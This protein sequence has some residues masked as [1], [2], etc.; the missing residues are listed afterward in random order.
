[1]KTRYCIISLLLLVVSVWAQEPTQLTNARTDYEK[2]V[3]QATL[4]L[5]KEYVAY[6]DNL[7]KALGTKGD[8][9]GA[10]AVQN[11]IDRVAV[12]LPQKSRQVEKWEGCWEYS[13][14]STVYIR[15]LEK[16][17]L[18]WKVKGEKDW[19]VKY[20]YTVAKD[21]DKALIST[22]AMHEP[23]MV[24]KNGDML[25]EGKFKATRAKE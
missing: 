15:R 12:D 5:L 20:P 10:M 25:V 22:E 8:A 16:G 13:A 6:L 17:N 1:M 23:P 7:K 4:P 24:F 21:G 9:A 3:K 14:G 18:S 19:R 11:E 2:K